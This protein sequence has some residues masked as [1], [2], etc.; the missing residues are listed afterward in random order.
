MNLKVVTREK[1]IDLTLEE[2]GLSTEA[3]DAEI[4]V[5]A[6]RRLDETLDGYVVSRH[7]TNIMVSPAPVFG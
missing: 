5:A 6:Q 4:I 2:L 1:E 7:D 3:T